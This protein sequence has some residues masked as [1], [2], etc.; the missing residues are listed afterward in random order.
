MPFLAVRCQA[1]RL[2]A[3]LSVPELCQAIT[4]ASERA[5]QEAWIAARFDPWSPSISVSSWRRI[6]AA[7][8]ATSQHCHVLLAILAN[9]TSHLGAA[10]L[11]KQ[12]K[13][14]AGDVWL[15]RDSWRLSARCLNDV[16]T[17]VKWRVSQAATEAS[18]LAVLTG[19]LA[20]ADP[21]WTL[22]SG[23]DRPA[24]P[25]SSPGH[26]R[27]SP[28]CWLRFITR[29]IRSPGSPGQTWSRPA[30]LVG[31]SAS[32]SRTGSRDPGASES[33]L[34]VP[35]PEN[36]VRALKEACAGVSLS[37]AGTAEVLAGIAAAM[38]AP[39]RLLGPAR[40]VTEVPRRR[41]ARINPG[42]KSGQASEAGDPDGPLETRLREIGVTSQRF[43]RRAARVDKDGSA[44]I[45]EALA[46]RLSRD[47]SAGAGYPDVAAGDDLAGYEPPPGH[48]L[49]HQRPALEGH[50][51][52]TDQQE[53]EAEP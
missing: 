50:D 6:A 27:M 45:A 44:V 11:S 24:R 8:I 48:Q 19:K 32:S 22:A 2:L 36:R 35:A 40:A 20:Y 39:S 23:P 41:S 13:A 28:R 42:E 49:G 46:E 21:G 43:L 33:R 30:L 38:R 53:L 47:A 26:P 16:T 5:A 18:D 4:D 3:G 14:A 52:Q 17:E 10:E 51:A 9:R 37:S 29:Q 15:T 25:L 12:L 31:S 34:F 1:A 7:G